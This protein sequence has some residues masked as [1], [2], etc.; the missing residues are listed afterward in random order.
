MSLYYTRKVGFSLAEELCIGGFLLWTGTAS[1]S[2]PNTSS[3][4]K[5]DVEIWR[6]GW[7]Q[8]KVPCLLLEKGESVSWYVSFLI[9]VSESHL[10]ISL[11]IDIHFV[12]ACRIEFARCHAGCQ[13]LGN[14]RDC[15]EP[16]PVPVI[17]PVED[18]ACGGYHTGAISR[19]SQIC[20]EHLSLLT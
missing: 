5:N 4:P 12:H 2:G 15:A 9:N 7:M 1:K 14:D 19:K 20:F 6:Q 17:P 13:G 10:K 3:V 16:M 18:I 8:S 11:F